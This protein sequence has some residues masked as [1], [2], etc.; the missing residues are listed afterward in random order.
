MR[1]IQVHLTGGPLDGAIRSEQ[2]P[3]HWEQLRIEH[4]QQG[5]LHIYSGPIEPAS[6][7]VVLHYR[8][9]ELEQASDC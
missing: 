9:T 5:Q 7:A 4:R 2:L 1:A 6:A 8:G 3:E